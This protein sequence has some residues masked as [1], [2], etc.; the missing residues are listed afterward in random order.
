MEKK[1]KRIVFITVGIIAVFL[2]GI[3]SLYLFLYGGSPTKIS[4][5]NKYGF[6]EDFKG[7]SN[8]YTFPTKIPNSGQVD[9]YYYYQRDTLFDPTCQIFLEYSLSEEDF[10][11][12]VSRLSKITVRFENERYKDIVN[13]IV[14]DTEHF[15]YPAYVTIYNNNYCYEYALLNKEENKIICVFTQFIKTNDIT[16]DKKYLPVGF[17]DDN[18]GEGFNVYYSGN[19]TGY[20]ERHLNSYLL[21]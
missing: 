9:D 16:F 18:S 6:F 20:F 15:R 17:G 11:A 7:Y 1:S 5:I 19:G 10:E 2:F 4:D 21:N 3:S 8:L 12:E 13:K 14:Y